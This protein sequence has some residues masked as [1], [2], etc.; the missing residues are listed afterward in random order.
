[1]FMVQQ[2]KNKVCG[3]HTAQSSSDITG[4]TSDKVMYKCQMAHIFSLTLSLFFHNLRERR[5]MLSELAVN[6]VKKCITGN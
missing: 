5:K 6:V 1:M 2:E 4:P 3:K